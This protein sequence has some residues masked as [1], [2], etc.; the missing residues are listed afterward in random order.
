V[1]VQ[2]KRKVLDFRVDDYKTASPKVKP[3]PSIPPT[4]KSQAELG[5]QCILRCYLSLQ[6]EDAP[7]TSQMVFSQ[8]ISTKQSVYR[9][10][11]AF[12]IT[13]L[14]GFYWNWKKELRTENSL[15]IHLVLEPE[16]DGPE[17]FPIFATVSALRPSRNTKGFWEL[18]WPKVPKAAADVAGELPF[19]KKFLE[20]S[21]TL[22]SDV[23]ESQAESK[24]NW[25]LYQFLDEKRKCPTVEWRINKN[26]LEEYGPLLRGSLFLAFVGSTKANRGKIRI[27]FRPQIGFYEGRDREEKDNICFIIPTDSWAEEEQVYID[28]KP[29]EQ[30]QTDAQ[31]EHPADTEKAPCR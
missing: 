1:A 5:T 15:A 27:L 13:V 12:G 25:F 3:L 22:M 31:Q 7:L 20:R 19:A 10:D 24:K 8:D 18:A 11:W 29:Q 23:L 21:L 14:E 2:I 30:G 17:A 28:V 9:Y 6:G 26:V 4:C 16:G